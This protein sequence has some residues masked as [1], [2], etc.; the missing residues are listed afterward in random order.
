[1]NNLNNLDFSKV[2]MSKLEDAPKSV[3]IDLSKL[4]DE[5]EKIEPMELPKLEA[6]DLN[7]KV[8]NI[9]RKISPIAFDRGVKQT[10]AIQGFLEE[11]KETLTKMPDPELVIE[12]IP[13]AV[14][15]GSIYTLSTLGTQVEWFGELLANPSLN[16]LN[17]NTPAEKMMENM[18]KAAGEYIAEYG[19]TV[20]E[21][22]AKK[23]EGIKFSPKTLEALSGDLK[24]EFWLKSS[25]LVAQA[26]PSF[27]MSW[28]VGATTGST[29]AAVA[30]LGGL[31]AAPEYKAARK[32]GKSVEEATLIGAA[33]W[34]GVSILEYYPMNFILGG[35]TGKVMSSMVIAGLAGAG[36]EGLQG[37]WTNLVAKLGYDKTRELMEGFTENIIAGAGSQGLFGGFS[38]SR[39]NRFTALKDESG[40][41]KSEIGMLYEQL[42]SL[43]IEKAP[44]IETKLKKLQALIPALSIEEVETKLELVKKYVK[45]TGEKIDTKADELKVK[46]MFPKEWEK[47]TKTEQYK[48]SLWDKLPEDFRKMRGI[49]EYST[50]ELE[51]IIEKPTPEVKGLE[52]L[53]KERDLGKGILD[54]EGL[55]HE[56]AVRAWREKIRSE[57]PDTPKGIKEGTEEFIEEIQAYQDQIQT[58]DSIKIINDKLFKRIGG[59]APDLLKAIHIKDGSPLSISMSWDTMKDFDADT[60]LR[61]ET[62]YNYYADKVD[63]PHILKMFWGNDP[64]NPF[65]NMSAEMSDGVVDRDLL[66]KSV[67]VYTELSDIIKPEVKKLP[68]VD[69]KK[70]TSIYNK[71]TA[72]VEKPAETFTQKL[73]KIEQEF[74]TVRARTKAE[75]KIVQTEI[76]EGLEASKL[77]AVDKAKFIRA[78]KNVQTQQQLIKQLPII[79]ERVATLETKAQVRKIKAQIKKTLK[80]TKP[81][82]IAGKPKGRFTPEVQEVLD[83]FRNTIKLN[84]DSAIERLNAN[85]VKEGVPS[86]I[87]ALENKLLSLMSGQPLTPLELQNLLDDISALKE[88][89]AA[90]SNIEVVK[91]REQRKVEREESLKSIIGTKTPSTSRIKKASDKI[92]KAFKSL[93]H[94]QLGW[95]NLMNLLAIDDKVAPGESRIEKITKVSHLETA[96]KRTVR[97]AIEDV[98]KKATDSFG[99]TT[100]KQLINKFREDS[101]I[102]SLGIFK[103]ARNEEVDLELS[104]SEARKLWMEMQDKTLRETFFSEKGNA[105]TATM[106]QAVYD[107]LSQEDRAFAMAQLDF[108]RDFYNQVNEVY[109][110]VYGINLPFNEF[111]SPI[112]REH[113]DVTITDEFLKEM[114][115]RRSVTT[116][117]LK[118]RISNI[119]PIKPQSDIAVLQKHII[120]MSHFIVWSDKIS[121]LNNIFTDNKIKDMIDKKFGSGMQK[122]ININISNYTRGGIDNSQK[123]NLV[124]QIRI[125]FTRSVLALKPALFAKQLVSFMAFADDVP[126]ADFIAGVTDFM[127]NPIKNI[128]ILNESEF[129]KARGMNLTRDIKDAMKSE[130]WTAFKKNPNFL[131]SLM[132]TTKL[133]DRGAILL[134][135]WSVYKAELKRTG[136][137]EKAMALF[138]EKSSAAQQSADL[139]QLSVFQTGNSFMKLFTM[140]TSSQNQYY[141]KEYMAIR[142]L[143]AGKSSPVK[144]AKT[145]LIY[146]FI[147]PMLF[148]L[149]S[150]FGKWD[151]EEQLRAAIL[152]SA[153]GI[154]IV[155]DILNNIIRTMIGLKTYEFSVAPATIIRKITSAFKKLTV[156]DLSSE[157]VIEAMKD[158]GEVGGYVSS[159]P[160]KQVNDWLEGT[161]DIQEGETG[162]GALKLLGWSPY[163]IEKQLGKKRKKLPAALEKRREAL[164][165]RQKI[166]TRKGLTKRGK[167]LRERQK[168]FLK[169][170]R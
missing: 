28:G 136:S 103:N 78:I 161:K 84:Q 148:Q 43:I 89:G 156:D 79:Q 82:K 86:P 10:R 65:K 30:V 141:R 126:V 85:L 63:K 76:I 128:E 67:N 116:G 90:I 53:A 147:L 1:M 149:V 44:E 24:D 49:N 150:D 18:D 92:R 39:M 57:Y 153:N 42:T 29:I 152:G 99:F 98:T 123:F 62:F 146:H 40:L 25:V 7:T 15:K 127:L 20:A 59:D 19:R 16:E 12:A 155:N 113:K 167:E 68:K 91:K 105:Y 135:G 131:N 88:G 17:P 112:S 31:E 108:Y 71:A 140:F 81:R 93:S 47:A 22:W 94:T 104:R 69:V 58:K 119:S 110:K 70:F 118:S 102:E 96:E 77:E 74:K 134:G 26:I 3:M 72:K 121:Q 162:R 132:I 87:T 66:S 169:R 54:T 52:P 151:K 60:L 129:L 23:A 144:V 21:Y 33:V 165:K 75:V 34:A 107:F 46:K 163:V 145:I 61:I 6:L 51:K 11:T 50:S 13:K 143:I 122:S 4:E 138:E 168:A 157:D 36:E 133:G 120:E 170:K 154:F 158:F 114:N 41:S 164:I 115:F 38:A 95:D 45:Q 5:P 160:I 80:A 124:D 48:K 37:I 55:T 166:S 83:V 64:D 2:D 125:N 100:E 35:G 142:N 101:K 117:S 130:E 109:S 106:I 56:Q 27:A 159:L 137:K 139:S 9:I 32:A 111:Y 73:Q 97:I 8:Q 14:A